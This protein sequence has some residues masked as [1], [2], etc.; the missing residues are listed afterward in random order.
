M[1]GKGVRQ[2]PLL[3]APLMT[4]VSLLMMAVAAQ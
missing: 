3:Y 1:W 4:A 2:L